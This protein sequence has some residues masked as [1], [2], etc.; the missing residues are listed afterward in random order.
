M[1]EFKLKLKLVY[2][3]LVD[4]RHSCFMSKSGLFQPYNND[5]WF[6]IAYD[7]F[8]GKNNFVSLSLA[9]KY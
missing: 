2:I 3:V 1:Y 7:V 9:H 4:S 5:D 8:L 6:V